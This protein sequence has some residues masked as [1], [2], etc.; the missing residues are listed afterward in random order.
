M[1]SARNHEHHSLAGNDRS[2]RMT[3]IA[4]LDDLPHGVHDEHDAVTLHQ[5]GRLGAC[6]HQVLQSPQVTEPKH[7]HRILV[8]RSGGLTRGK[9]RES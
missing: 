8:V 5:Y 9:T 3:S 1:A 2:A 6:P 7:V 4:Y